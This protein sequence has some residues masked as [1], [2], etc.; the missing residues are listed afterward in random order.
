ML[1][2]WIIRLIAIVSVLLISAFADAQLQTQGG[3]VPANGGAGVRGATPARA[4]AASSGGNRG[5]AGA[6]SGQATAPP[7]TTTPPSTPPA[8]PP[9]GSVITKTGPGSASTGTPITGT[10][11]TI[12]QTPPTGNP[13]PT[14]TVR[15]RDD[16]RGGIPDERR[17]DMQSDRR[18]G[19]HRHD[20]NDPN[21]FRNAPVYILP[22]TYGWAPYTWWFNGNSY[23]FP[24]AW[25]EGYDGNDGYTERND[26]R[27][28]RV[29][30]PTPTVPAN[31]TPAQEQ[32]QSTNALQG[33]P[34]YSQALVEFKAAQ[35]AYEDASAR[36]L[37]KL[38]KDP[39]YQRL[40]NQRDHAADRVEAVQAGAKIPPSVERVTPA[41]QQKLEVSSK[42]TKM[43]QDAISADPEAAA[44]KARMVEA[45][46]RLSAL[47]KQA[48]ASGGGRAQQ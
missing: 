32:A 7:K 27:Y 30:P 5:N 28:D 3:A 47:R 24:P 35:Q 17:D 21:R 37:A 45:N 26:D 46:A 29:A 15:A 12:T 48:E 6:G 40:L 38:R 42:V 31:P 22:Q 34:A 36:V 19:R 8:N 41:A 39:E 11:T 10:G 13:N 1:T 9:T 44:A 23:W 25:D 16:R 20:P 2:R 4:P 33:M 43:E 14:G 18:R